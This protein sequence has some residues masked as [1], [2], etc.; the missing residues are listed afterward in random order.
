[1]RPEGREYLIN[2]MASVEDI[3]AESLSA[4]IGWSWE[5]YPEYLDAVAAKRRTIDI[6]SMITHCSLRAYVMGARAHEQPTLAEIATMADLVRE[7]VS[8]GAVGLST[9]RTILHTTIEG[10]TVPG[11]DASEA[12]LTALARAVREGGGGIRGVLEVSPPGVAFAEP[13]DL[14]EAV[15]ML[16]RVARASDCPVVFSMLQSNHKPEDYVA[17]LERVSAARADGVNVHPEV[18]TRPI[19]TLISFQSLFNPFANL[20]GFAPLKK[21]S[22]EQRIA[23]LKDPAL[24]KRLVNETNPDP[25]GLDLVFTSEGF[26]GQV[27][28]TGSPFNYYPS[29]ADSVQ[30]HA[31]KAGVDAREI[32]YDAMM[33]RDGRAFLMYATCNWANRNR[34]ALHAMVTHPSALI[35]LGDGGAH[36]TVA[37]DFSQPT[38]LLTSWVRDPEAGCYLTLEDA[39]H[40]LSLANARVFGLHDR[41]ALK[42]GLKADINLIDLKAVSIGDPVME[43][44]LPL[45]R[46]RLDQ[47]ATG[48][49]A[50]YVS[51]VR[52]Q[53]GGE[54]TGHLPGKLARG[55]VA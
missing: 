36:V 44:D 43:S 15:E 35:G 49:V 40:K 28:I 55:N 1:M 54:L 23:A 11:T 53:G 20:P 29:D 45:G 14:V 34:K 48:Y 2:L 6:A 25:T 31:D 46:P 16:I 39:V 7:A 50:T 33:A 32:A 9:S 52:I 42:P 38:T 21:L 5:S 30:A 12:E 41:G 37:G 4:G 19:A 22:F 26:W 10:K 8:A 18:S 13:A 51:G 17:V 47:R 24:R 27:F 3:P